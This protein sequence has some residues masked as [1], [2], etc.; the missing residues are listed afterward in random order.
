MLGELVSMASVTAP[1]KSHLHSPG[2]A[3]RHLS[4]LM[5]H[6]NRDMT[7]HRC[8]LSVTL[9]S[10]SLSWKPSPVMNIKLVCNYQVCHLRA[11]RNSRKKRSQR[12]QCPDRSI[13]KD[14]LW[15]YARRLIFYPMLFVAFAP[16]HGL[17]EALNIVY[18]N[19]VGAR[20]P[21]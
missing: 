2:G 10:L 9:R 5:L 8:L 20:T 3:T 14:Q 15:N 21:G 16:V 4:A 6:L 1:G 13:W 12:F 17:R 19:G 7:C 11:L 18:R